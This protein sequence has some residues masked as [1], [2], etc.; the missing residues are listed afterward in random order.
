MPIFHLITAH[1]LGDFVLQPNSLVRWKQKSWKGSLVHSLI[2]TCLSLIAILPYLGNF[3]AWI[4][5]AFIGMGHFAQDNLKVLFQKKE[6]VHPSIWPFFIDQGLHFI[7]IWFFGSEIAV[8]NPMPLPQ[9]I[10]S[11]Y[12]SQT[13]SI[14]LSLAIFSTFTLD[15]IR[16]EL[17]RVGGKACRYHRDIHAIVYRLAA[18]I[19]FFTILLYLLR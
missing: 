4:L 5:V 14:F 13:L 9:N 17:C 15:I 3:K 16:F 7:L 19:V 2:I 6:E 18:F 1:L 11:L 12:S 8:L 10:E